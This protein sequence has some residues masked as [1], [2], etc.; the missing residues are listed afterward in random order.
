MDTTTATV[1]V[2]LS[3]TSSSYVTYTKLYDAIT[4]TSTSTLYQLRE[5][6]NGNY[7]MIFSD[8]IT[9]GQAPAAGNKIVVQYLFLKWC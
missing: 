9:T 6:P 4:V 7:E 5:T 3:A 2:Y 8:G 1:D